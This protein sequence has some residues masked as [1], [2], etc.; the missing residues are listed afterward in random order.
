MLF[1]MSS[2]VSFMYYT[3]FP[4]PHVEEVNKII[5]IYLS[6]LEFVLGFIKSVILCALIIQ[7]HNI[8]K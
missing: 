7:A 5:V 4:M 3:V 8:S 2:R 1:A 6:N